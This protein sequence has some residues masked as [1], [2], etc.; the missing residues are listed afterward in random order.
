MYCTEKTNEQNSKPSDEHRR[1]ARVELLYTET[2]G[3]N[4]KA[5]QSRGNRS[6]R[7]V[8]SQ[9]KSSQDAHRT[10][11][12]LMLTLMLMLLRPVADRP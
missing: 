10:P 6:S 9:V 2:P 12:L 5:G 1:S 4:I 7:R 11:T 8:S 3:P